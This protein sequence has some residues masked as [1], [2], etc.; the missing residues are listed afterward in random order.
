M[1]DS[2]KQLGSGYI[3]AACK[4]L[5]L[6]RGVYY[7][8]IK[9]QEEGKPLSKDQVAVL[10]RLKEMKDEDTIKLKSLNQ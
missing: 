7:N 4:E 2:K 10:F 5:G 9:N 1:A 6:T 8:A 3:E